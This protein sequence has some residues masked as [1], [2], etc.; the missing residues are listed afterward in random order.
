MNKWR[1]QID[2][3]FLRCFKFKWRYFLV[4]Q[5]RNA[6]AGHQESEV[7]QVELCENKD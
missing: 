7:E 4:Y 6:G 1:W 3:G 5:R 2:L